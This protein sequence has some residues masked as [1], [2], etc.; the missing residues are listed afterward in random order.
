MIQERRELSLSQTPIWKIR[1]GLWFPSHTICTSSE[2][3]YMGTR[4]DFA[5][6][7]RPCLL[8]NQAPDSSQPRVTA[9]LF[10]QTPNLYG[11]VQGSSLSTAG[12]ELKP[13]GVS[14]KQVEYLGVINF[15]LLVHLAPSG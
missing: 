1:K 11:Q 10:S 9:S 7:F 12:M 8:S 15:Q 13:N 14:G 2:A 5:F 6:A 4:T 3:R